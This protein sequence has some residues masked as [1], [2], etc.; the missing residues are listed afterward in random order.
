MASP[1]AGNN[2]T[3]V[4]NLL[5]RWYRDGG[6]SLTTFRNRPY[7]AL[8]TKKADSSEVQGSTFQFAIKTNDNQSRNILFAGAQSQAWG[9]SGY[10]A[11]NALTNSTAGAPGIGAMGITQFS[12]QRAY[13]YAYATISTELELSSRTKKGA[14]DSAMT[15]LIESALNVLGNDQEISLFG[16]S[17][18]STGISTASTG[19]LSTIGTSTTIASST[20]V[21]ANAFDSPKFSANQELDLYYNNGGTITKRTNSTGHGLFVG[22]VDRVLGTLSIVDSTGAAANISAIFSNAATGDFICVTNDFNQGAATGIQGTGKIAGFESWVPFGGP[23]GDSSSNLFMGVNRNVGDVNRL[24]G[25]W[26]DATGALGPNIG[27]VL[28]I[29]D[30]LISGTQLVALNSSREVDTWAMNRNQFTKLLKSNVNRVTLPGGGIQTNVPELSF[31][32]IEVETDGGTAVVMPDRFCGVNRLYGLYMPSWSY[33][34]LG[35][36]VDMYSRDGLDGLR[37]PTMDAKGYRFF[38]FGNTVC[39]EP[40]ANVTINIAP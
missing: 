8:L 20:L 30:A 13:N 15:S 19:F 10:V 38:S 36:P 18:T 32:A 31:K 22:S 11:T 2:N 9:L 4:A 40:S 5:K 16:G 27:T 26:L 14:F 29:E 3:S 1:V 7:W 6:L 17:V 23:V 33:V 21:L 24:A 28:N 12:V 34:H 35:E 25:N 39:D 37:E